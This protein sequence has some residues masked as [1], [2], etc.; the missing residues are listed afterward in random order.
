M[1]NKLI[2]SFLAAKTNHITA[3][4]VIVF[5]LNKRQMQNAAT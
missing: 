5:C 3:E 4:K 2:V 1:L